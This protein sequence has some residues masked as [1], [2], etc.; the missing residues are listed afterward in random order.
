MKS[1][2]SIFIIFLLLGSINVNSET[3]TAN[4]LNMPS[5]AREV[6]L[7][8]AF[9]ALDSDMNALT[10]NPAGLSGID[11]L[12]ASFL[13]NAQL[14]GNT[15]GRVAFA[16][17]TK[18]GN[19]GGSVS[20]FLIPFDNVYLGGEKSDSESLSDLNIGFGL[21]KDIK[22]NLSIGINTKFVSIDLGDVRAATMALDIGGLFKNI[23]VLKGKMNI[24]AGVRNIGLGLKFGDEKETMPTSIV[25]GIMFQ[26][27]DLIKL[28]VEL[29]KP[30][31]LGIEYGTGLEFNIM[32]F[33]YPRL[34]YKGGNNK[35]TFT[36]GM[37]VSRKIGFTQIELSYALGAD[38]QM[39]HVVELKI[40]PS[41][42]KEIT[43]VKR[44]PYNGK[45]PTSIAVSDFQ[46]KGSTARVANMVAQTFRENWNQSFT[47]NVMPREE[48]EKILEDEFLIMRPF[49][50][51]KE[52]KTV[53]EILKVSYMV[54]GTVSKV[55]DEYYVGVEVV[56]VQTGKVFTITEATTS[57]SAN[58]RMI[59][60]QISDKLNPIMPSEQDKKQEPIP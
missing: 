33:F 58:L 40:K 31:D 6:A 10:F 21:Q 8:G 25:S 26:P 53:G 52:A 13:Y 41:F 36:G 7:G 50:N 3:Q 2:F 19:I 60:R 5:S 30:I 23:N 59:I 22:D 20:F 1:Y 17:P 45:E 38:V 37:T 27:V 16:Y 32:D 29:D 12:E 14:F 56:D 11:M 42:G 46:A 39:I 4:F 54:I 51:A 28:L 34:G 43:A 15:Y 44:I 24:G 57:T 35:N 47:L 18:L 9:A 49:R 48:M 55:M